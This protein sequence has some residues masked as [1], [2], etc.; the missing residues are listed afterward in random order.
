MLLYTS[1]AVPT[2]NA[3]MQYDVTQECTH[4]P[5][6][7]Q[8]MHLPMHSPVCPSTKTPIRPHLTGRHQ[9]HRKLLLYMFLCCWCSQSKTWIKLIAKNF[10]HKFTFPNLNLTSKSACLSVCL[11]HLDSC[12]KSD[13]FYLIFVICDMLQLDSCWNSDHI[14]LSKCHMSHVNQR[15]A[16]K[17]VAFTNRPCS[18]LTFLL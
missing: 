7:H 5:L 8:P 15:N 1:A 2:C 13:H 18:W 10:T 16:A 9:L 11:S 3:C 14:Y 4:A 17:V 6:M 12:W